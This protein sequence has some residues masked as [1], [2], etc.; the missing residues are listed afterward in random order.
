MNILSKKW[1][2]KAKPIL[3]GGVLVFF[4]YFG[5]SFASTLVGY[6]FWDV[7]WSGLPVSTTTI[8][9][10]TTSIYSNGLLSIDNNLNF[11]TANSKIYASS[12]YYGNPGGWK[13][14]TT[15]ANGNYF[16]ITSASS[17]TGFTVLNG[18]VSFWQ[19]IPIPVSLG[20]TLISPDNLFTI[21]GTTIAVQGT[22]VNDGTYN[23]ILWNL[24]NIS[25]GMTMNIASTTL[26]QLSTQGYNFIHNIDVGFS[27]T[28]HLSAMLY[29][30]STGSTS[31]S[32]NIITFN[33]GTTTQSSQSAS[34]TSFISNI[35]NTIR[36]SIFN[37][38][39]NNISSSTVSNDI[40]Q[41]NACQL[42]G[43]NLFGFN[44]NFSPFGCVA[45]LFT[46]Q[47]RDM[48]IL[49]ADLKD[50][51]LHVFPLGYITDTVAILSTSSTTSLPVL[52]VTIPKGYAG[53]STTTLS[54]NI[55]Q[56]MG[57]GT[58]L[59]TA[60]SSL[61]G[62]STQTIWSTISNSWNTF[63]YCCLGIYVIVRILG[64]KYNPISKL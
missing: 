33:V 15:F 34:T 28:Y 9:T 17:Y 46:P 63:I 42:F 2:K 26:P 23:T 32:S 37:N 64:L 56:L 3:L 49:V 31:A 53:L 10:T 25:I 45:F 62:S 14:L 5:I 39:G 27:G 40:V 50:G 61:T 11:D 58:I 52:T 41:E 12:S 20:I 29:N 60:T 24:Q 21:Y 55:F 8:S 54:L 48:A 30:S 59:G 22:F 36:N 4:G 35:V 7:N 38:T 44:T 1:S 47:E 57:P 13:N 51:L 16:A 6:T 18:V 43:G 19:T